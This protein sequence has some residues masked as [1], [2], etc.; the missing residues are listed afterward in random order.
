VQTAKD[1]LGYLNSKYGMDNGIP[2]AILNDA[3]YHDPVSTAPDW[4]LKR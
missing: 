4:R 2:T 1:K 3:D